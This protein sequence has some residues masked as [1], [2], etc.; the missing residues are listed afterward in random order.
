MANY[1]NYGLLPT[2]GMSDTYSTYDETT[3]DL[4][5]FGEIY[6]KCLLFSSLS[7]IRVNTGRYFNDPTI[8]GSTQQLGEFS[9]AQLIPILISGKEP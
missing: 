3:R 2:F 9:P 1:D 4:S 7:L 6:D 8:Y 5:G